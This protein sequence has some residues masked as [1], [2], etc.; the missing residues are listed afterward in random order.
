V[1]QPPV[2]SRPPDV[3]LNPGQSFNYQILA[4][5]PDAGS[6]LT[7]SAVNLPASLSI[8]ANTGMISGTVSAAPGPYT[9]NL[10]V[11]DQYEL[12]ATTSFIF[13]VSSSGTLTEV[14]RINAGGP[15]LQF[16]NELWRADQYFT[17]GRT[18]TST[19]AISNTTND[20][21]YQTERYGNMTY[22]IPVPQSGKYTVELHFAEINFQ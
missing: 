11:K 21:L 1:N 6:V 5:D 15:N 18:F 22:N 12:S 16:G 10:T 8:N 7:Y 14:I 17:G 9:V 2:V 20:A 19:S 4:S 13:T 3:M